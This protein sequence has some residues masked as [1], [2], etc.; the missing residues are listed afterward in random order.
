MNGM[1]TTRPKMQQISLIFQWM[2]L[3]HRKKHWLMVLEIPILILR[4]LLGK[5]TSKQMMVTASHL[6]WLQ[7]CVYH[8]KV[9]SL[10]KTQR[11]LLRLSQ[12]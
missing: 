2:T 7:G 6:L 10:L 9:T 12:V 5:K 4:H 8:H 3:P 11:P 1:A